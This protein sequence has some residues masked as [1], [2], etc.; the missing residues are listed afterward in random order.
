MALTRK[1]RDNRQMSRFL[2][3]TL[4]A[5]IALAIPSYSQ[6]AQITGRITDSSGGVIAAAKVELRNT[7][8]GILRGFTTN[9]DGYYSAPLLARGAYEISVELAGFRTARRRDLRV[10]EG[11]T[12]R[13]DFALEVGQVTESVEVSGAAQLLQTEETFLGAVVTNKSVVDLPLVGRNPLALAALQAGVRATG[14]FGDLPVSSFDGSRASIGGGPPSANNYMIDGVAAENFTSGGMNVTLSVDATEEFRVITKNPSA[15]FGRTAGGVINFT[16]KA[17]TNQFHGTAYEFLRNRSLNANDFFSNRAN[18]GRAPFVFNQWGATVGGP[19]KKDRTFFFFNYEE[20]KLRQQS[21]EFRTVPTQ[22]QRQGNFSQTLAGAN[23]PILVYDPLTTRTDPANAANRIRDPFAGNI[24]PAARIHGAA[25][26]VLDFYPLPNDPGA[27]F[28]QANNFFGQASAPTDKKILGIRADHYFTP[29]RRIF[30]RYTYDRTFRASPAYFGIAENGTSD[31]VFNRASA[32]TNYS[33]TLRPNLL[34]EARAGLNRYAPDRPA[35]SLG[36]DVTKV[37]LPAKLNSQVQLPLVP[38]YSIA[39]V[40][41]IGANQTDHLIQANYAW[42][43]GGTLT[44]VKASHTIKTGAEARIYQLNNSQGGPVMQFGFGRSFT[45]GPNPNSTANTVGHGL[46]TFL[47]GTP[48][49]GQARRYPFIAYT[50]KT[51]GSFVQDD[52][53]VTPRL[54]LNLGVRWEYEGALTE[55]YNALSNFD[56]SLRYTIGGVAFSGGNTFPGV[57]GLARGYRDNWFRQFGPRLGFAYQPRKGMVLRGGYGVYYAPTT[58]NFVTFPYV[59]YSRDTLMVTSR[60][61]GFTPA[62]TLTDPFPGG[63][64]TPEGAAAGPGAALGTNAQGAL[65]KLAIPYAQQ[66]NFNIQKELAGRWLAEI[67]YAANRGVH[68]PAN[69]ALD[70]LPEQFMSQ[71]A[72]LQQQ[73]NNPYFGVI[74]T[75]NLSARTVSQGTLLDTYPQFAGAGYIEHWAS[76]TYQALMARLEK[77]FSGGMSLIVSY[78][79]TKTIDDNTGNGVN[80]FFNGGSDGVQNWNNL[81]AERAVS[82]INLP[83]RLVITPMWE[84]PSG[85]SWNRLTRSLLGGWQ[86]GGIWTIQSGEPISITQN[87][88]AFGGNRPNVAGDPN[89]NTGQSIDRWFNTNAFALIPAFTFGNGP[90]NLPRTRT[91]SFFTVDASVLKDVAVMERVKVQLRGEAFNLTNS[92][93]FGNPGTNRS[94]TNF[95]VVAGYATNYDP[96][97]IQLALKVIF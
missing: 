33:D 89:D 17:G 31:L 7:D 48:D 88:V 66:W 63:I 97:R 28:T 14:R 69:R 68:M 8:T 32:V 50:A 40:T 45:R 86:L 41:V 82:T 60:D 44:W 35:R 58:G 46:A 6:T 67:G 76:S 61:G 75:G 9:A 47:L 57:N 90:R 39:D 19:V 83:H 24:I 29:V 93:T 56:P 26:P 21:R 84:V 94:A 36:F 72:Q 49:S 4:W 2:P 11:Q 23:A 92:P 13:A 30:G 71:G 52:W 42:T 74:T 77:R 80:G 59:G 87:G 73:V 10:D 34:F 54:T 1:E 91:D 5:L 27:A 43:G 16:S 38:Q 95:G 78:A 96:R 62:D 51:L 18:R 79:F 20:F 3:V 22:L 53:K 65:R 64:L 85:K 70:F 15:E 81:R 37:G 55:R 12:L 25:R